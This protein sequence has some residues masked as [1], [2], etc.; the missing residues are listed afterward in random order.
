ML[1]LALLDILLLLG[2]YNVL[3]WIRFGRPAGPNWA[4]GFLTLIWIDASYLLGRYSKPE[5]GQIGL[6]AQAIGRHWGRGP[7]RA[8]VRRGGA[9]VGIRGG[10][11][12]NLQGL[13]DSDDG[14]RQRHLWNRP[15]LGELP[16]GTEAALAPGG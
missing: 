4:L 2:F 14:R 3:T 13:R 15:D 6:Q 7:V 12:S 8:D 5:W 11:P 9:G 16:A 10:G 1:G